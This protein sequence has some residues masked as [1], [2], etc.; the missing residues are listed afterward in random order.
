MR[1]ELG[2]RGCRWTPGFG[3][4]AQN[5]VLKRSEVTVHLSVCTLVNYIRMRRDM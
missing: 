3:T 2:R 1:K 5:F 4:L